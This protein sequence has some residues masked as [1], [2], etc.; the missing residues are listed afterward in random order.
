MKSG[1]VLGRTQTVS[2]AVQPAAGRQLAFNVKDAKR[3]SSA[4][5]YPTWLPILSA[6]RI[7]PQ[8]AAKSFC[9]I[10]DGTTSERYPYR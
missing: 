1:E 7:E 5:P 3:T 9:S 8:E 10:L 4:R 6:R 2:S